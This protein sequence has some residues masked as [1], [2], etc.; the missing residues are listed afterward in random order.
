M[1]SHARSDIGIKFVSQVLCVI[2]AVAVNAFSASGAEK[3]SPDTHETLETP[4]MQKNLYSRLFGS[5]E[6]RDIAWLCY[7]G[8]DRDVL[9]LSDYDLLILEADALGP[10][11]KEAK[12]DRMCLAYMSIGEISQSRWFWPLVRNKPWLLEENPDWP[13]ARRIDPRSPEWSDLLVNTIAPALLT[14]GYDGFL[15]DNADIGEYLESKDP[16]TYAGARE[17]VANIIR[18]LRRSFPEAVLIANGAL[19]TAADT[20]DCLDAVVCESTV[21]RWRTNGDGSVFYE[22]ISPQDRAWLRPRL[23]RLRGAGLPVL[24]LEYV[25]PDDAATR[26]RVR[27]AVKNAGDHPYMAERQLMH[28]PS[29]KQSDSG[30]VGAE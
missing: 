15:L 8:Q 27:E 20:A 3:V 12:G 19:E 14:A 22:Q 21:S 1:A 13:D 18:R 7:Y 17:A 16:A 10:V 23:L 6:P 24:A 11:T 5:D 9:A 26:Q 28:L 29:V 2:L 4:Y 30:L 25:A